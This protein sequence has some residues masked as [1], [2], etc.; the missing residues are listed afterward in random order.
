MVEWY[1]HLSELWQIT[2]WLTIGN[3]TAAPQIWLFYRFQHWCLEKQRITENERNK[4]SSKVTFVD[5][6]SS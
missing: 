6:R 4:N 1:H 2:I 3:L 5:H